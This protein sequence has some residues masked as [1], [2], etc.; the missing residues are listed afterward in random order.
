MGILT[1][2]FITNTK[3]KKLEEHI[4]NFEKHKQTIPEQI[5]ITQKQIDEMEAVLI[6]D[7][8]LLEECAAELNA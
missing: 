6:E 7:E 8:K 3:A 2:S 1:G 5:S 4:N